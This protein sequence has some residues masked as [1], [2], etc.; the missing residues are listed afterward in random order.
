MTMFLHLV[1]PGRLIVFVLTG[2]VITGSSLP[3]PAQQ[4]SLTAEQTVDFGLNKA[5]ALDARVGPVN[6][7][8]ITFSDRGR[9]SPQGLANRIRGSVGSPSE[10]SSTLR[11]HFVAENPSEDEWEVTFTLEFLDNSGKLVEKVTAKSSWEGESKPFDF[12]HP[13]L[14]YVVPMIAKVRIRLEARLD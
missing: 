6:V 11:S 10:A 5:A 13:V 3:A 8:S 4:A 14:T 9:S 7:Q 12:D 2:A 1:R